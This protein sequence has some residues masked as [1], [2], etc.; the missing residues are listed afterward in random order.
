MSDN[1]ADLIIHNANIITLDP[2]IRSAEMIAIKGNTILAVGGKDDMSRFKSSNTK[3]IDCEGKTVIPGF[4]D[5]HCH[6]I[7]FAITMRY[8]D[9]SPSKVKILPKFRLAFVSILKAS[10]QPNG[11]GRQNTMRHSLSKNDTPPEK[12]WMK[13]HRTIQPYWFMTPAKY[14]CSTVWR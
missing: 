8:V 9:C 7:P 13:L 1:S 14:A 2:K 4:N 6:P 5:A 12:I 10:P 3:M 11:S